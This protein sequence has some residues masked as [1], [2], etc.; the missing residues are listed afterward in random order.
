LLNS[1][2]ISSINSS[3][4]IQHCYSSNQ[5]A[6]PNW[7][8]NIIVNQEF[9]LV[10][11]HRRSKWMSLAHCMAPTPVKKSDGGGAWFSYLD[12]QNVL[13]HPL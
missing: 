13:K 9:V 12:L 3:Y 10:G 8:V 5:K 6:N 4:L 7:V 11:L 1:T 2:V